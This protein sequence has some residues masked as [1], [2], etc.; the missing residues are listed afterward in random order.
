MA[1]IRKDL[2]M[3][4]M[5][6][7]A[8]DFFATVSD[9]ER[10][11]SCKI[12]L[13]DCLMSALAV[14]GLKYSSLLKFDQDKNS[15]KRVR[16]NLKS[17][18]KIENIPCD[19][20]VRE[21]LDIINPD[22]IRNIFKILFA[23]L[24]RG[25][26]LEQYQYIDDSYLIAID[27]TGHFSSNKVHCDSCCVKNHKDGS[28]SYYHHLLGAV[29]IHPTIKQ[30]LPL[31]PEPILKQDG[32]KKNDCENIA[33]Y[34]LLKNIR[35]E[36]PH[37]KIIVVEDSLYSRGPTLELLKELDMS[38]IIGV[39]PGGNSTLF[40]YITGEKLSEYSITDDSGF[41]H[42]FSFVNNI[43]LNDTHHD[44]KTNFISYTET[45]KKGNKK[46]FT[47]ISD[48]I[49]TKDNV[50]KIMRAGRARWRIE[51]ETFN[52]LKNQGYNFDH[53]FGHGNKHL[54]TNFSMLMLLSF[55]ID[56]SQELTSELYRQA[57]SYCSTKASLWQRMMVAIA[58]FMLDS[59]E[60]LLNL[61]AGNTYGVITP[62]DSS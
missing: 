36:H 3:S 1:T 57:R 25:K 42:Q 20:Q 27:G 21:R 8:R 10:K 23:K 55:F 34:R 48:K 28:K 11:K 51:N 62:I 49:I 40:D 26:V 59:W 54:I 17:L 16:H 35:R 32:I 7:A 29:L 37:L 44:I 33:S 12:D 47:W 5:L 39:K 6:G 2:S 52:T 50:Y 53:N 18:Y 56:Q 43:P 19:T 24:Q 60:D 58:L 31:C 22:N 15:I 41:T 13:V 61:V 14:F 45:D 9:L 38:Y 30:V 46:I 4:G